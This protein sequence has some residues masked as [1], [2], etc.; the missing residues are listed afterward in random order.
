MTATMG[1]ATARIADFSNVKEG[2]AFNPMHQPAGD[3]KAKIVKVA[4]HKSNAG[5]EGWVF[6]IT[7]PG[8]N[9]R[10]TYPYYTTLD[11]K[12]LWKVRNLFIAAGMAVPKKR[13]KVDP[14]KLVG[15]VIGV[16]LEDDEYDGKMKSV[17]QATFPADELTGDSPDDAGDE[18]STPGDDDVDDVADV[19]D[20]EL[21]ELDVDE[22]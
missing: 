15:K 6:S 14:N 21:D 11:E 16:S 5:N 10:A 8:G 2:S 12:S 17:I 9:G 3:Y 19:A 18:S 4:D 13:V 22:L 7:T 20:D 1:T